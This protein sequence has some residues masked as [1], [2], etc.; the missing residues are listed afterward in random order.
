MMRDVLAGGGNNPAGK[1]CNY[2]RQQLD[3]IVGRAGQRGEACPETET[4]IDRLV[5][6]VM[7]RILF[8]DVPPTG[9]Y[10]HSLV[11]VLMQEPQAPAIRMA[12]SGSPR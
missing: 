9:V 7:F 8:D 2:T 5:A 3:V 4:L 10:C 6:P 1:C 11:S 12:A